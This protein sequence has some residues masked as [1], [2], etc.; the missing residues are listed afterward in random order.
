M[1]QPL[2]DFIHALRRSG[3]RISTAEAIDAL[4]A[5]NLIGYADR[6]ILRDALAAVLAKSSQEQIIFDNCFDFFF[7]LDSLPMVNLDGSITLVEADTLSLSNLARLVLA[8][9]RGGLAVAMQEAARAVD[10][11]G[12]QFFT[13]KGSFIQKIL[14]QVGFQELSRDLE[15]LSAAE[16]DSSEGV[17]RLKRAKQELFEAVRRIVDRQFDLFA[18]ALQQEA[19]VADLTTSRLSNLEERDYEKMQELVGKMVKRLK[20]VYSRRRK[21]ARK[22]Y[23]DFKRTLRQNIVEQGLLFDLRWKTKKID[24]PRVVAI[25]D[26]SRSV[27]NITRFFLLFLHTLDE[28]VGSIQTFVFCSNL[29]EVSRIFAE[30]PVQVAVGKIEAADRLGL[31]FGLTDY[32]RALS[33]FKQAHL[34][35]LSRKT[36]VFILGDARNN[37]DDPRADIVRLIRQKSRRVIWLNP[38]SPAAWGSGDSAMLQYAPCCDLAVECST[39]NHLQKIVRRLLKSD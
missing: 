14:N 24:S 33:E 13:Q 34:Q 25:C 11:A 17:E 7:A 4:H 37:Y 6:D 9:D 19:A 35:R 10:L 16:G 23:L 39:L 12:M 31:S 29:L 2:A 15:T 26:V 36:T 20:T 30:H 32:G 1:E 21:T 8:G 27:K 22:G 38:E 5:I 18:P 3:V 28:A